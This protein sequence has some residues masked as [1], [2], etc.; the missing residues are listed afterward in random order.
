MGNFSS[1]I[2][3]VLSALLLM[4]C[5]D[6]FVIAAGEYN[7]ARV[8]CTDSACTEPND[9]SKEGGE[10]STSNGS[11]GPISLVA[12]AS[13]DDGFEALSTSISPFF[14]W[15]EVDGAVAYEV[16]IGTSKGE[17]DVLFWTNIKTTSFEAKGLTL[18][19]G[20][21]YFASVRA[22]SSS[23]VKGPVTNGDGFTVDALCPEG[24]ILVRGNV[25][26]GLG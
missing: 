23:G 5:K 4:S 15:L 12:P 21:T 2:W 25:E 13:F 18:T 16:S 1:Q 8:G 9:G 14:S 3:V 26:T 24:Y 17:T 6:S 11:E 10:G 7:E 22:V 19:D 20:Q